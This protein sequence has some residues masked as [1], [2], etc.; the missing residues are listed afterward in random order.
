MWLRSESSKLIGAIALIAIFCAWPL[1]LF[2]Y[3]ANGD[4]APFHFFYT[5][6]FFRGLAAGELYPRWLSDLEGGLGA[7]SFYFYGP[8]AYYI[9]SSVAFITG[10]RDGLDILAATTPLILFASGLAAFVWLRTF[11]SAWPAAV[12]AGLYMIA[13]YH[14]LL[15]YWV[16]GDF[17]EAAAYIW[18]PLC[19]L[20]VEDFRARNVR[21]FLLLPPSIALL[22]MTHVIA[23]VLTLAALAVYALVRLRSWPVWFGV[24]LAGVSGLAMAG[25]YLLPMTMLQQYVVVPHVPMLDAAFIL[26]PRGT[27]AVQDG[28]GSLS[29]AHGASLVQSLGARPMRRMLDVLFLVEMACVVAMAI[30]SRVLKPSPGNRLAVFWI[31]LT[32]AMLYY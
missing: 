9:S 27:A 28:A 10:L 14:L 22:T 18:I 20:A 2:G 3:P 29:E 26:G 21:G 25:I 19:F 13:P 15:D 17:A 31:V 4:D 30:F 8:V 1:V 7:P 16:R 12:G 23:S 11:V 5:Q 24:T 32:A 6:G